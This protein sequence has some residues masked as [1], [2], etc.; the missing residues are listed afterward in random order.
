MAELEIVPDDER[1]EL[2]DVF[3]DTAC[4]YPDGGIVELFEMQADRAPDAIALAAGDETWTYARLNARAT[5]LPPLFLVSTPTYCS[6]QFC[7]RIA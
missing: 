5:K 7:D 2:L 1:L 6:A 4:A 3:N